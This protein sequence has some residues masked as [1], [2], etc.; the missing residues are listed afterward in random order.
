MVKK[1]RQ[2]AYASHGSRNQ[3][4]REAEGAPPGGL[5]TAEKLCGVGASMIHLDGKPR[6]EAIAMCGVL[7]GFIHS[8]RTLFLPCEMKSH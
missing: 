5:G 6:L 4:T 7:S 2:A 1:V 8:R 3:R